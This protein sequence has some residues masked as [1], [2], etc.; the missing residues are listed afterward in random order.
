MLSVNFHPFPELYTERLVLRRVTKADVSDFFRLRSDNRVM[1][2]IGRPVTRNIDDAMQLVNVIDDLLE[3][4][5]GITW[6]ISSKGEKTLIGTIGL[7]RI[8]KEHYRAEI[9]YL[10]DPLHQGKGLMQEAMETVLEFGFKKM[11]LHSIEANVSPDN[12]A[13]IRLLERNN[14]IREAHFRENYFFNEK[15][16]DSYIYS[17]ITPYT[18]PVK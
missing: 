18:T 10:L 16:L 6:A 13:S 5:N 1:Q 17:L 2:Y 9:G 3:K 8:I 15:F 14:F 12:N 7:W 11:Q 4:S